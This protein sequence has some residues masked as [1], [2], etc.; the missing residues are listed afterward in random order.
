[1]RKFILTITVV[2]VFAIYIIIGRNNKNTAD[3][4]VVVSQPVSSAPAPSP[5]PSQS[6]TPTPN[7]TP[8]SAPKPK[9]QYADGQYTGKVEDA[10]YGPIQVK[11]I[12]QNGKLTDVQFLQ[13]PNDRSNSRSI[14]SQAAPI[15]T[16]EA[17]RAQSAAVDIVSGATDTS[18]AF[19]RSL[20]NALSQAKNS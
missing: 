13:Y 17:V 18:E 2:A 8:A 20:S 16:Q 1:M 5:S 6:P 7:S 3:N 12:I 14:N 11:A 10:F 9:G 4:N 19:M 15:L